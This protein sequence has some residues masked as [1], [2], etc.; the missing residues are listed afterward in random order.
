MSKSE[1]VV[2]KETHAM[3]DFKDFRGAAK[4]LEDIDIPRIGARIGVGEDEI[5]AFMDVEAAGAGFDAQGRPKMLFEPHVF[6]RN[7]SGAK[8]EA[9]VKL[10]LAYPT[11]KRNY[12]SDSYPR[13]I[14]AM[15][16]DET[17]A[18]KAA[19]W[20]LGQVLG[21]NYKMVGYLSPQEMVLDFMDDEEAHL[22]AIV[23][24][25]KS[26][27]IA[28][29]LAAHK[30]SGVARVYNGAGYRANDY[31]GKMA[32]AF[33]R[34]QKIKDTPWKPGQPSDI[35]PVAPDTTMPVLRKGAGIGALAKLAPY[36]AKAQNR[37]MAHG[38][39][40]GGFDGK[41]GVD[42]W[43]AVVAF[44][45]ARKFTADGVIG[46]VT[47]SALLD[48]PLPVKVKT[49]GFLATDAVRVDPMV[50]QVIQALDN[51]PDFAPPEQVEKTASYVPEI[52]GC[53]IVGSA[54]LAAVGAI[55]YFG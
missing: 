47:W 45:K 44:Q 12:P 54:M 13:L 46:P 25:L 42:T 3:T 22:K 51:P 4:R 8:R 35:G 20:G 9:A 18:L 41:F 14:K 6:Y 55:I 2:G 30:W 17:A 49:A 11:W 39:D 33:A 53:T 38:F 36:V 23:A 48:V 21:E 16:I 24:F 28:D 43:A 32:R 10:G 40:T 19:S 52:I 15:A 7:L 5:H 50:A 29:D 34:W 26:A 27:H 37:L 31:D 1:K